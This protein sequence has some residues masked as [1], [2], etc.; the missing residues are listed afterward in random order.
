MVRTGSRLRDDPLHIGQG[1]LSRRAAG[2]EQDERY[3]KEG[4]F[5]VW[6]VIQKMKV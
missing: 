2:R 3:R 5:H 4:S 6:L 1:E